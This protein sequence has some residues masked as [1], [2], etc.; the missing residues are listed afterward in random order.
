MDQWLG[1]ILS[2][3]CALV[4]VVVVAPVAIVLVL[5]LLVAVVALV[6]A[7]VDLVR[8]V[9]AALVGRPLIWS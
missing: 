5:V 8:T 4:A 9:V 3:E 6:A 7:A 2:L 1:S